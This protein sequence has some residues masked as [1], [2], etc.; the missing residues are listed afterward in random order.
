ML[1]TVEHNIS[2]GLGQ[3]LFERASINPRFPVAE[4][5]AFHARLKESADKFLWNIDGKMR[6][7]EV[8]NRGKQ[9]T[10]LGVGVF[11]FEDPLLPDKTSRPAPRQRTN[12]RGTAN[13]RKGIRP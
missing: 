11:A 9:T 10:R 5:S 4:L 8:R 12:R 13:A 2:S 6:R 1:R 3:T 7:C